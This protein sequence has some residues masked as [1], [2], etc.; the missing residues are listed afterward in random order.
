MIIAQQR[1]I[2]KDPKTIA[3]LVIVGWYM[4]AYTTEGIYAD[5]RT[6]ILYIRPRSKGTDWL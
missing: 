5:L 2:R 6:S 4:M 1:T 3:K